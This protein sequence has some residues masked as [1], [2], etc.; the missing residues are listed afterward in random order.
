MRGKIKLFVLGII[1]GLPFMFGC[2]KT[3]IATQ[4]PPLFK[5]YFLQTSQKFEKQ[6]KKK[7]LEIEKKIKEEKPTVEIIE[8]PNPVKKELTTIKFQEKPKKIKSY[9]VKLPKGKIQISV[10]NMPLYDFINLVFGKLLSVNYF[11][12]PDVASI[13]QK[14]TL[15]MTEPMEPDDFLYF[16]T[17]LLQDY[18]VDVS[19]EK[20]IFKIRRLVRLVRKE[21]GLP[22]NVYVGRELPELPDDAKITSVVPTYYVPASKLISTISLFTK[23]SKEITVNIVRHTSAFI[24][25]GRYGK[26]KKIVGLIKTFDKP[27]FADKHI[28]FLKLEYVSVEDFI[29]NVRD[30]FE[31]MGIKVVETQIETGISLIPVESIN[32]IVAISPKKEWIDSLLYWKEKIDII[33]SLSE[34]KHMFVFKPKH[35]SA[36]ELASVLTSIKVG[37]EEQTKTKEVKE[38]EQANVRKTEK[39]KEIAKTLKSITGS[40]DIVVDEA[41]NSLIVYAYPSDY[42]KIKSVLEQL[43]TPPKQV[44][45][46]V[47]I[48]EITLKDELKYGLE[49]YI[50]HKGDKFIGDIQTLGGLGVGGAGL[51]YS[52]V[53]TG[54]RFKAIMNA[55][56]KKDLINIISTPHIVVL[57]GSEASIN[58][59]TEVPVVSSEV[60]SPDLTAGAQQ[61][62]I[63]RNVQ[64]RSTGVILSVTP[65]VL[66]EDYLTINISQELS[67]AQSN[68]VSQI[69]SP[70]IIN[71]SINTKITLKSGDTVVLGGLISTNNSTGENKVPILGDIPI[72]GNLFKV[73]SKGQ[74]KTELIIQIT[75]Y[76]LKSSDELD[77]ISRKFVEESNLLK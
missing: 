52:L 53:S 35:R 24:V 77:A 33:E 18:R 54:G 1:A 49:W 75:P 26:V 60:T 19:Y 76:I 55:F 37:G 25:S 6:P 7:P 36:K 74:S 28:Y 66:S 13:G 48:A 31:N 21:T 10:E 43:D 11:I 56:A 42:K 23:G 3:E 40:F 57:D 14:I 62:S 65:T 59:G 39:K 61:P 58:V 50:R 68:T 44:L 20:G 27:Y 63:L 51:V 47:T 70:I 46:E 41:R 72:L 30:I 73:R 32:A 29:K 22:L 64:Y 34:E 17:N 67:E 69:D 45:I 12:S 2:A 5:N 4:K 9:K 38:Q 8:I 16:V 15:N 71:R